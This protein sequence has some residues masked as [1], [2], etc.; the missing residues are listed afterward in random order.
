MTPKIVKLSELK[1]HWAIYFFAL[2][3]LAFIALFQYY[4]AAL[5]IFH[6]F[7][8]WNGADINEY[9]GLANYRELLT[10]RDFWAS[11]RVALIIGVWNVVKM[12]PAVAVAVC[13]NRARSTRMQFLYRTMFVAPMVIPGLIVVLIWRT[14]FFD[15]T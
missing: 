11:F 5:G 1:Y 3:S 7:Y 2:P 4:P 15:A 10:Q 8:R 13:I 6:S 9:N 14:F 12:I